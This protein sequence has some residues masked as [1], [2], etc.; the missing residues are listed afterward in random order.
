MVKGYGMQTLCCF[1]STVGEAISP[2]RTPGVTGT[3]AVRTRQGPRC[4][5]HGS[6]GLSCPGGGGGEEEDGQ[7]QRTHAVCTRSGRVRRT[8]EAGKKVQQVR[9]L[10]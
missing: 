3:T 8:Y 7:E 6:R 10:L 1:G 2:G 5:K 4:W 9:E